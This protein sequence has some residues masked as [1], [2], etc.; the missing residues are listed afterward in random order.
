MHRP[1]ARQ[2]QVRQ[3]P[4]EQRPPQEQRRPQGQRPR[5]P[6]LV[7]LRVKDA[8]VVP[9]ARVAAPVPQRPREP[10]LQVRVH[11]PLRVNQQDAAKAVVGAVAV[12][13]VLVEQRRHSRKSASSNGPKT[14]SPRPKMVSFPWG[15]R[16]MNGR[17]AT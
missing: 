17:S 16:P 1:R 7:R 5:A 12:L 14:I 9:R 13:A 10:P 15:R 3:Q 2:R 4:Q 8:A 11:R 6:Q